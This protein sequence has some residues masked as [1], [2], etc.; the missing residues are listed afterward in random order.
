MKSAKLEWALEN[1][2]EAHQL[3]VEGIE[4]FPEADKLWMMKGTS[5]R[6]IQYKYR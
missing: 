4:L 5:P 3:V 2:R 6:S 1:L